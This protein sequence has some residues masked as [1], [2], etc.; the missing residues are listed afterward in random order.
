[1]TIDVGAVA[2]VLHHYEAAFPD[3]ALLVHDLLEEL[4]CFGADFLSR[5][6]LTGHITCG[7]VLLNQ[8][9]QVLMIQ[10][11]ALAKWLTPGGHIEQDD[12][13][14]EGAARRELHEETGILS[15]VTSCLDIPIHID[16]H[17]IPASPSKSEPEHDHWDFRFLFE[18]RTHDVVL[19]ADEV[20]GYD[21]RTLD[22]LPMGLRERVQGRL[23]I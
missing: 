21:W 6:K 15:E 2:A 5:T 13:S 9:H 4:S 16:R 22:L 7:A 19:Q 11:K 8:D 23:A 12:T 10:H 3:H 17:T 14:L 1:M 18:C 20:S